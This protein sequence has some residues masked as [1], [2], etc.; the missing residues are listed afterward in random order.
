VTE[1][2]GNGHVPVLRRTRGSFSL[3]ARNLPE[4]VHRAFH[5]NDGAAPRR[6]DADAIGG[7]L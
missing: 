1:L 3:L 4:H 5:K 6:A 2:G 7:S